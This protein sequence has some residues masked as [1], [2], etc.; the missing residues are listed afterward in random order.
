MLSHVWED[1]FLVI[2]ECAFGFVGANMCVPAYSPVCVLKQHSFFLL[3]TTRTY[4]EGSPDDWLPPTSVRIK[5]AQFKKNNH[6]HWFP[7]LCLQID[8]LKAERDIFIINNV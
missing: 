2:A 8:S 3:T 1:R 4:G 6:S 7:G 5:K